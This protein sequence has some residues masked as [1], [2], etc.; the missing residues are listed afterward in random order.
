MEQAEFM[1][2][3]TILLSRLDFDTEAKCDVLSYIPA[4]YRFISQVSEE[5]YTKEFDED[6]IRKR[7]PHT[8]LMILIYKMV[9]LMNEY[10]KK[11]IPNDVLFDTL[12]DV[13]LRQRMYLKQYGKLGLSDEDI[14][15]LKH[16]YRLN[17][18]KL[19]SLQFE[20]AHMNYLK[21]NGL[22]YFDNISER[23][24]EGV[25]ILKVHIRKGIDLSTEAVD[26]SFKR[27]ESFFIKHYFEHDFVAYTCESWLLYSGNQRMLPSSC[28]ILEF[29]RRFTLIG[30]SNA[31]D[32]TIKHIF[33]KKYK[34]KK[35]YP[36]ETSLQKK[37][38]NNLSNL[39]VGC[40]VIW[41][42]RT[43]EWI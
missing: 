32:M 42:K 31:N 21:C 12:S 20:I 40:G 4:H 6:P 37:A 22:V 23:L 30:E 38:L 24:P 16:I 27:A 15:W 35:A 34:Y 28:H 9:A 26:Q 41:R 13:T 2:K 10:E 33:G 3:L 43:L 18:F 8:R 17:I 39:G 19:G 36:Q 14:M 5:A 29:A 7:K 25:P 1:H 11:G